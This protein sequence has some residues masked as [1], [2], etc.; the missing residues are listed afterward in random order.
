MDV[1]EVPEAFVINNDEGAST[2]ARRLTEFPRVLGFNCEWNTD[3]PET[4]ELLKLARPDAYCALFRLNILKHIPDELKTLLEDST[5][6]KVGID[7]RSDAFKLYKR[8]GVKTRGV[9]D[10]RFVGNKKGID[11]QSLAYLTQTVVAYKMK[12]RHP[13]KYRW[14]DS[15]L[16]QEKLMYAAMDAMN[17]AKLFKHLNHQVIKSQWGDECDKWTP[18]EYHKTTV[19][20]WKKYFGR[21]IDI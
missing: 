14:S 17:L 7:P 16:G 13:P 11:E 6:L 18:E 9:L 3:S 10:I 4:P 21:T 5:F 19:K 8:F 2:A 1:G 15:D 12:M 20:L